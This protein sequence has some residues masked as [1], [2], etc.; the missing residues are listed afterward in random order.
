MPVPLPLLSEVGS[1]SAALGQ[2]IGRFQK[3]PGAWR[4]KNIMKA[5]NE[6]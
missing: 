1:V 3:A 6:R 4:M 2:D 5:G